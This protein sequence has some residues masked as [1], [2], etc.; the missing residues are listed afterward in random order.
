MYVVGITSGMHDSSAALVKSGKIV[1]FAEEERFN[2]KKHTGEIPIS[3]IKFC[4]D[5]AG[6]SPEDISAIGFFWKPFRG[7]LNRVFW[8]IKGIGKINLPFKH[9]QIETL[10][11]FL[12]VP[13]ILRKEYGFRPIVCTPADA[14]RSFL[15]TEMDVLA[16]RDFLV[17]KSK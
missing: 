14:I 15:K 1:A 5:Y 13:I 9:N 4:L 12:R 8:N 3:A 11:N 7:L 6:I 16:I 17:N 2:R 10:F